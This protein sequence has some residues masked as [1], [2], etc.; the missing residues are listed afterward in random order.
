[1]ISVAHPLP[2]THHPAP[3]FLVSS[4][5][6][7]WVTDP[8]AFRCQAGD[9]KCRTG[10]TGQTVIMVGSM[11]GR[12]SSFPLLKVFQAKVRELTT[13]CKP[14]G[15]WRSPVCSL[16]VRSYFSPSPLTLALWPLFLW[17]Q[18]KISQPLSYPQAANWEPLKTSL[19]LCTTRE[20][21]HKL[22]IWL[23]SLCI[24]Q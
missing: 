4:P 11:V 15:S 3:G 2:G 6:E 9:V 20:P 14:E 8:S 23:H 1:M 13:I 18:V 21:F 19:I 7:D 24:T 5:V 22:L 17:L 12:R 10:L 16:R